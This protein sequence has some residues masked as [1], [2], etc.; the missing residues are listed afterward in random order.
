MEHFIVLKLT[1]H[2]ADLIANALEVVD[3]QLENWPLN[4]LTYVS[5]R[6]SENSVLLRKRLYEAI[7][8]ILNEGLD[9]TWDEIPF[10]VLR[11]TPIVKSVEHV[12]IADRDVEYVGFPTTVVREETDSEE[13]EEEQSDSEDTESESEG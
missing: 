2:E 13:E 11:K 6:N 1:P 7:E 8:R 3:R 4:R 5:S 9:H 12:V 10:S